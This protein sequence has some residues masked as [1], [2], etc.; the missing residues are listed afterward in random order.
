[1]DTK[2]LKNLA[3]FVGFALFVGGWSGCSKQESKKEGEQTEA[4]ADSNAAKD[5]SVQEPVAKA[6]DSAAIDGAQKE[7]NK[8]AVA[9]AAKEGDGQGDETT[10][11]LLDIVDAVDQ[12]AAADGQ[13]TKDT[14]EDSKKKE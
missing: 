7:E 6:E 11:A 13:K 14:D 10:V 12:D 5:E 4:V 9:D 2:A 8:E 3:L 1:M